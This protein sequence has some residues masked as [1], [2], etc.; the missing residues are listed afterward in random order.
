MTGDAMERRQWLKMPIMV[1]GADAYREIDMVTAS[2]SS[3]GWWPDWT[4]EGVDG[5]TAS[6]DVKQG[7]VMIQSNGPRRGVI[8]WTRLTDAVH[9]KTLVPPQYIETTA[10]EDAVRQALRDPGALRRFAC[11]HGISD[12]CG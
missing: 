4:L 11:A 10:Q 12:E 2:E 6:V 8:R 9:A 1:D 7:R 5:V 3:P